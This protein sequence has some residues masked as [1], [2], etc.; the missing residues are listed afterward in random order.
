M[1]NNTL[2]LDSAAQPIRMLP[3]MTAADGTSTTQNLQLTNNLLY[4]T[5][6]APM[7]LLNAA[8]GNDGGFVQSHNL[9]F[10]TGGSVAAIP[11]DIAPGGAGTL[12]DQDPL[13]ASPSTGDV[14]LGAG[15][16]AVAAGVSVAGVVDD[17]SGGC[18][19]IWNIGAF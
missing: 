18:R 19:T 15:S 8:T 17:G 10:W 9:F 2:A 12:V 14:H 16:P 1:V 11:S 6:A 4:F 13:L 7:D 5:G 3:G